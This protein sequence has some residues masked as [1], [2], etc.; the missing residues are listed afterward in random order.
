VKYE[1]YNIINQLASDGIG[2]MVISSQLPELL[3]ICS[4]IGVMCKGRLVGILSHQE[5]T[6]E[7]VMTLA[8]GGT[9]EE[10]VPQEGG[11]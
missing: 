8:T 1:I 2:V 5:A 11:T 7:R 4:R 3:G 9:L 6:Q 10:P